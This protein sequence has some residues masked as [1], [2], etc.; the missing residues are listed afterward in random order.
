MWQNT[1][2]C[3]EFNSNHSFESDFILKPTE[4]EFEHLIVYV[5]KEIPLDK[6][7]KDLNYIF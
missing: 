3:C 6:T 5:Q 7:L 1:Y 2:G 4:H